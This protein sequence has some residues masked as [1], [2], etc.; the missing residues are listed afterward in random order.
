MQNKKIWNKHFSLIL[1]VS[2]NICIFHVIKTFYFAV[3]HIFIPH[4]SMRTAFHNT[5]TKVLFNKQLEINKSPE[6]NVP[7]DNYPF[8]ICYKKN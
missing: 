7:M 3:Y 8:D 2:Q 4:S 1:R 5:G 6:T